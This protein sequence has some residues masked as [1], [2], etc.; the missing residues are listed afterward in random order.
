MNLLFV[1]SA[2]HGNGDDWQ[3]QLTGT[4]GVKDSIKELA[5]H[6]REQGIP[7]V[8]W[9]KEDPPHYEDF[10]ECARLFDHVFTTDVNKIPDYHRD[11]GHDH[12]SVLPFAAQPAVHNP[13]RPRNGFHER[14]VA[15]GGMYFAHKFPERREQM[16][17][18]LGGADDVSPKLQTGLEIFSRYLGDDDRY[19]FP[20]PLDQRVVGSLTYDQM[21]T[22]YK[23]Y[24]VFLNVNSVI[25]SPS[26]CARRIF[27]ITA[28]GTPVV[29]TPSRAIREYFTEDQLA[30]VGDR[31]HAADVV[32]ALVRSPELADRMVH[33]AQREVWNKHTYGHRVEQI[34]QRVLPEKVR[35]RTRPTVSI[36]L[37]T[38]RP[39]RVA[40]ALQ[41]FATQENVD[42]DV[43]M[44]AHGFDPSADHI[45]DAIAT[46]GIDR[47]TTIA[48]GSELTL[49]ECLNL[50][51][52]ASTGEILAKMDDDDFYAP[53]YLADLLDAWCTPARIWSGNRPTTCTW[54]PRTRHFI[55][56]ATENTAS[57][58]SSW[59]PRSPDIAVS[60]IRFHSSAEMPEKIHHSWLQ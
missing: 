13:S 30:V 43:V 53:R 45:Q 44:V 26:M 4:S 22:A 31:E 32:R 42:L 6:C 37:C 56:L 1:E 20:A 11:L 38:N 7:T 15:F 47:V 10:L 21:L 14:D 39:H 35:P 29:S 25:D 5:T 17:L 36:L 23:A 52:E 41:G 3:Y 51:V 8:F 33:R 40:S 16:D 46:S 48:A 50:A 55:G 24:R 60:L 57:R 2:W 27:E 28:S 12:V 49:G 19:Q 34:L 18:L 58:T 54:S 59:A 9:N